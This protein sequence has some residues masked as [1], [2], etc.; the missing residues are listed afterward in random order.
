MNASLQRCGIS[1]VTT[2][3]W[4]FEQDVAAYSAAGWGAIGVWLHKLELPLMGEFWF[5]NAQLDRSV[6]ERA[7]ALVAASGLHVSHVICAGLFTEPDDES[8]RRR[9]EHALESVRIAESLEADC[10]VIIPGRRLGQ[11]YEDA[12]RHAVAALAEVLERSSDS[13][14]PL[15]IEPVTEVDYA[16][17]VELALDLIDEVDNPRLGVYLDTYHA[18]QGQFDWAAAVERCRGRIHGVHVADASD[19]P[20]IVGR[21]VPGDGDLA[22]GEMLAAIE[23]TGYCGHYDVEL[24]GERFSNTPADALMARCAERLGALVRDHVEPVR[25]SIATGSA[26]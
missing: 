21:L 4:T 7:S 10:L 12:N 2:R 9:I 26:P 20:A 5:P 22:L 13:T 1:Q 23:R 17:T 6:V 3:G 25:A 24:L 14:L 16:G 11:N 18:W 15:A 8:R 19:D